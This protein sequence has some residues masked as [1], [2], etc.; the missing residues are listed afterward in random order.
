VESVGAD[1]ICTTIS[2]A[3]GAMI[4]AGVSRGQSII[5]ILGSGENAC[6]PKITDFAFIIV[7]DH[8]YNGKRTIHWRRNLYSSE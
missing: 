3:R 1:L 5:S 2:I 6:Q 8:D 7:G 4:L